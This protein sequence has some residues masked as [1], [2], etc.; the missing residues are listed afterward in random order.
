A[1]G[2]HLDMVDVRR[3]HRKSPLDAD[4][5]ALLAHGERLAD[6]S[7]LPAEHH[8]LE[9]LDALLGPFD[10]LDVHVDG[11]ARAEGRE[12]VAQ[13][14]LVDEVQPVHLRRHFLG[15]AACGSCPH[16]WRE[17]VTKPMG[18]GLPGTSR[19]RR[20]CSPAR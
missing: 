20:G 8:A 15:V 17:A 4:A 9:Y 2:H 5:I 7:A 6:A 1:T 19:S 18:F 16:A 14:R 3:M 13:R 11:V 12:V 10:N